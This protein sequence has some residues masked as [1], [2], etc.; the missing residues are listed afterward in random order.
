MAVA[1]WPHYDDPAIVHMFSAIVIMMKLIVY[2]CFL[3]VHVFDILSIMT[4]IPSCLIASLVML[5]V[6]PGSTRRSALVMAPPPV[7]YF[8]CPVMFTARCVSMYVPCLVQITSWPWNVHINYQNVPWL[9]QRHHVDSAAVPFHRGVY[10]YLY[11]NPHKG[12]PSGTCQGCLS[13]MVIIIIIT[14]TIYCIGRR[15]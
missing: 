14:M 5:M 13:P 12:G 8:Q 4:R 3:I 1:I 7:S 15:P 2:T 9:V 6:V 11:Y 10:Y